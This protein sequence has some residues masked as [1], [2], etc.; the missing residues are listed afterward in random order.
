MQILL[1]EVRVISG[2]T[3]AIRLAGIASAKLTIN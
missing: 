2:A 3:V 1:R